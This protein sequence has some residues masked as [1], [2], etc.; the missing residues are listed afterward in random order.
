MNV[1]TCILSHQPEVAVRSLWL[2]RTCAQTLVMLPSA[3]VEEMEELIKASDLSYAARKRVKVVGHNI[4]MVRNGVPRMGALRHAQQELL[5]SHLKPGD[6]G[7]MSDQDV[8]GQATTV[9]IHS[10]LLRAHN[11][12][13]SARKKLFS[14]LGVPR[15]QPNNFGGKLKWL[16]KNDPAAAEVFEESG[17]SFDYSDRLSPTRFINKL[18]DLATI[19]RD[20]GYE[21]FCPQYRNSPHNSR[22]MKGGYIPMAQWSGLFGVF[23]DSRNLFDERMSVGADADVQW[24]ITHERKSLGV[25]TDPCLCVQFDFKPKKYITGAQAEARTREYNKIMR[26]YP[27]VCRPKVME[28]Q[29]DQLVYTGC[30]GKE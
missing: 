6:I 18:K 11:E 7:L 4:N 24:R 13:E 14:E 2:F 17:L 29:V 25:L 26:R 19:A 12:C 22:A 8:K 3:M 9:Y 15:K 27:G 30:Y 10:A 23:H 16:H 1:V 21:F 28:S 20:R 5:Q